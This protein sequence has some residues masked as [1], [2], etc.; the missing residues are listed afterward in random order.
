MSD[1]SG[2]GGDKP[3]ILPIGGQARGGKAKG[4]GCALCGKA[5]SPDYR[6]FC[7]KRCADLD[8]HRWLSG[9]YRVPTEEQPDEGEVTIDDEEP[10][11]DA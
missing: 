10:G 1:P 4:G 8:L 5:V 2:S 11:T 7:S 9:S 3:R 6:P